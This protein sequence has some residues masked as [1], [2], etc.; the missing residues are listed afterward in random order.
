MKA[1]VLVALFMAG[2]AVSYDDLWAE[3]QASGD[4]SKVQ[5]YEDR[6]LEKRKQDELHDALVAHCKEQGLVL[7]CEGHVN[8]DYER[9]CQCATKG[10]IM[11]SISW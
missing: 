10:G 9:D 3:A 11:G 5:A 6:Q 2:C 7:F 8:I 4:W 1:L